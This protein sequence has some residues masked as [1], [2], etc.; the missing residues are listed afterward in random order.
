MTNLLGPIEGD[1]FLYKT[2]VDRSKSG[3]MMRMF[4]VNLLQDPQKRLIFHLELKNRFE[5]LGT[6]EDVDV[7]GQ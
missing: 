2:A 4:Q 6:L 3:S 1:L 7:D 5:L